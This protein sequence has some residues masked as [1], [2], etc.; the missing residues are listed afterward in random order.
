[1]D[2]PRDMDR[3]NFSRDLFHPLD[4]KDYYEGLIGTSFRFRSSDPVTILLNRFETTE[5][6]Q[7]KNKRLFSQSKIIEKWLAKQGIRN[8][9]S[10]LENIRLFW[11]FVSK[12]AAL[13]E[14]EIKYLTSNIN[15]RDHA[16][17][18]QCEVSFVYN[19]SKHVV[20]CTSASRTTLASTTNKTLANWPTNI[21]E[22]VDE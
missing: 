22:F 14:P 8:A 20:L 9:D 10:F 17:S 19:R 11:I 3:S 21:C 16:M 18:F 5:N 4:G 2:I 12:Q 15:K 1:M 13:L 6:L 7:F